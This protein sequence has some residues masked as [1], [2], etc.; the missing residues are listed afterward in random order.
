MCTGIRLIA[1]NGAAVYARTLE[2]GQDIASNIIIIP[3]NYTFTGTAPSGKAEGLQWQSHYAVVGAN[4]LNINHIIDGVNEKGLAGGLFYFVDFAHYQEIAQENYKKSLAPWELITWILTNFSTVDEVKKALTSIFVGST[5][6]GPWGFVPPVHA[7]VHDTTGKSLVIEYVNENLFVYDN[8]LGA[9][10]N[11]PP[12]D[13]HMINLG[14]YLNLKPTNTQNIQLKNGVTVPSLGQG[15]GMLGLPGDFTP[16]SRFIRAVAFSQSIVVGN[17]EN[18]ALDAAFHLLNLFNIPLG[19]VRHL[20][21]N[22]ELYDYTQWTSASDLRNKR[23]YFHTYENPQIYSVDLMKHNL[24][25]KEPVII[26]M[27]NKQKIID[28][29]SKK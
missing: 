17:N 14:N 7:I 19:V 2:F 29:E 26:S 12:F 24:Q 21:N 20:E 8:P 23:Y 4:A 10:T 27:K 1:D 11:S 28:I 5:T 25:A 16:P 3:R 18:E 13:W 22:K 9:F 6:F 15:S